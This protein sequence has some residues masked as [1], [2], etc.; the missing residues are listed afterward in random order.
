MWSSGSSRIN[1]R[2]DSSFR[3][4]NSF[5]NRRRGEYNRPVKARLAK[6]YFFEAAQ[7]LP[8]VP[9]GH[10]CGK[11]HGHSFKLEII[12]EGEVNPQT[13]WVYD[14]ALISRAVE[15]LMDLLD[16]KYLNEVPGLENPT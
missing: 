10:K 16:H 9:P 14:H 5:G 11:M 8:N 15:P 6:D 13:G 3:C 1:C 4:I 2:C 12:V 7:T